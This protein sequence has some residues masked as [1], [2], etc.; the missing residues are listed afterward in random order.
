VY[1][2]AASILALSC[3]LGI[4]LTA[5]TLP[6]TWLMLAVALACKWWIPELLPWWVI[7]L[8][9]GLA[10]LGEIVEFLAASVGASRAGGSRSAMVGA[11]VG[12]LA[13][14]LLGTFL[15]PV[16]IVG[17]ILGAA[18]G[19][20]AGAIAAE[21]GVARQGWKYSWR[22]G[23]GAARAR[24]IAVLAKTSLACMEAFLLILATFA[25]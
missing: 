23:S 8:A 20:G 7:A 24:L 5:L 12:G 22:V 11:G 14:A 17:T 13:G 1:W 9:A 4:A 21:R 15:I 19:A 2:L 3:L 6:G 18:L 25:L 10:A 16:P